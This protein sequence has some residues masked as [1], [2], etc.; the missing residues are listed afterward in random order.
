VGCSDALYTVKT[1]VDYF[2]CIGNTITITALDISK[3]FDRISHYALYTKLMN[4]RVPTCFINI[5]ICWY[6]KCHVFVRWNGESSD[7]FNVNAGVRQGGVLS[8]KLF[9]IYIEDMIAALK[10]SRSGCCINGEFWGIFFMQMI[11]SLF[12]NLFL[13][14]SLC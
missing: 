10:G 12:L 3:A 7:I 4:R 8:P 5:L 11:Y 14:C 1:V 13:V 2:V 6:A 9:A